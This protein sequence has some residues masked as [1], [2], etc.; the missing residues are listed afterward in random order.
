MTEPTE[1]EVTFQI[2]L[3]VTDPSA[4]RAE[5]LRL[6]LSRGGTEEEFTENERSEDKIEDT[7]IGSWVQ[8]LLDWPRSPEFERGFADHSYGVDTSEF[9]QPPPLPKGFDPATSVSS[10]QIAKLMTVAF[11]SDYWC[12]IEPVLP[13]RFKSLVTNPVWYADPALYE[14]QR[15]WYFEIPNRE[16]GYYAAKNEVLHAGRRAQDRPGRHH[17]SAGQSCRKS[18]APHRRDHERQHRRR[19]GGHLF[20]DGRVQGILLLPLT[21]RGIECQATKY[22][23]ICASRTKQRCAPRS[24]RSP[25]PNVRDYQTAPRDAFAAAINEHRGRLARRGWPLRR[26]SL[27]SV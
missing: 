6:W 5:A 16:Y 10:A 11:E 24:G 4:M 8:A 9:Y 14:T 18:T 7:P 23:S 2:T 25:A 17:R 27:P 21:A 26:I 1:K 20:P 19:F 22:S 15:P 13:A 12:D 3:T